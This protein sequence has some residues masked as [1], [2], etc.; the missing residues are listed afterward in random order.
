[1]EIDNVLLIYITQDTTY[2]SYCSSGYKTCSIDIQK[3]P[4]YLYDNTKFIYGY[5]I[6]KNEK[7]INYEKQNLFNYNLFKKN[8]ENNNDNKMFCVFINLI[9]EL[10]KHNYPG[11]D[12]DNIIICLENDIIFKHV[13][14][15]TDILNNSKE[16]NIIQANIYLFNE[17]YGNNSKILS[18][19]SQNFLEKYKNIV[20]INMT[21]DFLEIY[22]S[23]Y[24]SKN[25]NPIQKQMF[26][27]N[28]ISYNI[29]KEYF[30]KFLSNYIHNQFINFN[31]YRKS[32][33]KFIEYLCDD[34]KCD[35]SLEIDDDNNIDIDINK[36]YAMLSIISENISNYIIGIKNKLPKESTLIFFTGRLFNIEILRDSVLNNLNYEFINMNHKS[37]TALAGYNLLVRNNKLNDIKPNVCKKK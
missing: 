25:Q 12:I 18:S 27:T 5:E 30:E 2:Y 4:T 11:F 3:V 15:L 31:N 32:Y 8:L 29:C 37:H 6:P 23:E 24:D 22:V 33:N 14:L 20:N 17:Y 34:E 9:V 13:K 10:C 19:L 16:Y 7:F 1:M 36:I 26:L 35:I 21:S 28:K